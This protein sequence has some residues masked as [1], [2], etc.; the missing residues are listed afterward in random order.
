MLIGREKEIALLDSYLQSD[1][2]EFIA[3]YGRRR[4]GKTF[5]ITQL[6]GDK[7]A[8]EMTGVLNA[9]KNEQLL[10]FNHALERFGYDFRAG[11]PMTWN[12]AFFALE[13]LLEK[14]PASRQHIVFI[15]E[16]P[17]LATARSGFI[18]AFDHFWNSWAS[19]RPGLKLIVCGSA[20]SWMISNL[21]NNHGGLHNRVTHEIHLHQFTLSETEKVL[22]A[23][24]FKWSRANIAQCY[25]IFG[26]VP[27]YLSLLRNNESVAQNVD[28]LCFSSDGELRQEYDRL[29]KS[30]FKESERYTKVIATLASTRKGLTRDEI[31]KALKIKTGGNLTKILVEL[32][33]CDFVRRY[34]MRTQRGLSKNGT[35]Q[36]MDFFTLFHCAFIP[37]TTDDSFWSKSVN[38]PKIHNWQGL[39]F[40]LLCM[41]HV[42][43]IKK[44]LRIDRI[45]TEHYSWRSRKDKDGAQVDLIIERADGMINMCEMKFS[46]KPYSV[47]ADEEKKLLRR[48]A[49]FVEE[50]GLKHGVLLTLVSPQ[51]V[52]ENSH[53]D[54]ISEV[55]TLDTLFAP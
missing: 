37:N 7:F 42:P 1:R 24:K 22:K 46:Q 38:S 32:Q 2:S 51:G 43:E 36:L 12:E 27:Y 26:G 29:Y 30:L 31:A 28:R 17:G 41:A 5:L 40:E 4:V 3:L 54:I 49:V 6:Y 9:S 15:D 19:R 39:T 11:R 8:F 16:L 55:I 13:S 18:S 52:L 14:I 53:S 44:G 45:R 48:E 25:M 10:Y 35:Y 34:H 50:T 20:T 21:I 23:K 33:N 47:T